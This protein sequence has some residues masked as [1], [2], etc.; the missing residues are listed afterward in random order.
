MYGIINKAVQGLICAEYGTSA[1][2]E[3]RLRSGIDAD[4]FLSDEAYPDEHTYKLVSTASEVLQISPEKILAKFGRYWV[5][6]TA[7]KNYGS[8]MQAGGSDFREFLIN[9][10][11][12]HS[13]VM[14]IYPKLRPPEF[15]VSEITENS[16]HL[17]YYSEREGLTAFVTG[18]LE[19]LAEMYNTAVQVQLLRQKSEGQSHDVFEIKWN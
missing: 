5:L 19:G 18:L 2:E 9:L 1:W 11:D 15:T 16:L 14:L 6:H 7:M 4:Y 3:V 10:P 8:L 12:F 17:H 13:R